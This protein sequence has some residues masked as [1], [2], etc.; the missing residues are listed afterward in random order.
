MMVYN[1][2]LSFDQ[3]KQIANRRSKKFRKTVD[4]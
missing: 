4:S 1:E 3:L 2:Y